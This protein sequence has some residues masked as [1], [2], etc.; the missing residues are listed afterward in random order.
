MKGSLAALAGAKTTLISGLVCWPGRKEDVGQMQGII[1]KIWENKNRKG[2]K[3]WVLCIAGQRYSLWDQKSREPL[4]K[5][6]LVELGWMQKG[7]FRNITKLRR[8][9]ETEALDFQERKS[10]QIIRMSCIRSACELVA[11]ASMKPK[12]K[13]K[14]VIKIAKELEN[15]VFE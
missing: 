9:S 5:G 10:R 6:D 7:D 3:Y 12:Q 13:C 8:L 14:V 15:H 1:Q 4:N 11:R 2:E